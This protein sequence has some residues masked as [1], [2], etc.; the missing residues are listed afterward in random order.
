MSISQ[1]LKVMV[2]KMR[3]AVR[4]PSTEAPVNQNGHAASETASQRQEAIPDTSGSGRRSTVRRLWTKLRSVS[5]LRRA[6]SPQTRNAQGTRRREDGRETPPSLNS[7]TAPSRDVDDGTLTSVDISRNDPGP[8][9]AS[10]G[11]NQR[12]AAGTGWVPG[13]YTST[14]PRISQSTG[15][16]DTVSQSFDAVRHADEWSYLPQSV[17][18]LHD[19][20]VVWSFPSEGSMPTSAGHSSDNIPESVDSRVP[21]GPQ[22]T[23]P[24]SCTHSCCMR[25]SAQ[26]DIIMDLLEDILMEGWI[27]TQR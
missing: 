27:E 20:C 14:H 10:M 3:A 12:A 22:Q 13:S 5:G 9:P 17:S 8:R 11:G 16:D 19:R 6:S 21:A 2:S 23:D 18:I 15:L 4:R 24:G 7:N 1:R 26:L 25:H